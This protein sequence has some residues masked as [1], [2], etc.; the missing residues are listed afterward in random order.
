MDQIN[1]AAPAPLANMGEP[2]RRFGV[3]REAYR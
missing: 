2:I 1:V 3:Y